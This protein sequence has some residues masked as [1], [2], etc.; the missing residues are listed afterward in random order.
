VT[1]ALYAHMNGRIIKKN[2]KKKKK[3]LFISVAPVYISS[4]ILGEFS[5]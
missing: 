5:F 1:Q 4:L 3:A 2:K